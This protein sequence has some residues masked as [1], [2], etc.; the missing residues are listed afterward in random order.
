M[1]HPHPSPLPSRERG[2]RSILMVRGWRTLHVKFI[3]DLVF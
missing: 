1:S 3:Q 2:L